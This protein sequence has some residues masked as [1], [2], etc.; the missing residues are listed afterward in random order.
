MPNISE[1]PRS[2]TFGYTKEAL[3]KLEV[4]LPATNKSKVSSTGAASPIYTGPYKSEQ[5]N[6]A[7]TTTEPSGIAIKDV[8]LPFDATANAKFSGNSADTL[9]GSVDV[10]KDDNS[11][12]V[13]R[14]AGD[15]TLGFQTPVIDSKKV[16]ATAG[17]DTESKFSLKANGEKW[18]ADAS[19]DGQTYDVSGEVQLNAD[20]ALNAG[21]SGAFGDTPTFEQGI[22]IGELGINATQS[23]DENSVT[24]EYQVVP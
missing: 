20:L 2:A 12:T 4:R 17:F 15:L 19:T 13:S 14:K 1:T 10:S 21:V 16:T 3:D 5:L 7:G 11:F 22:K 24:V 6:A 8:P 9:E 23:K 18:H